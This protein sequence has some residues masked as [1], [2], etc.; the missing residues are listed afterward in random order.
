MQ[1]AKKEKSIKIGVFEEMARQRQFHT[2]SDWSTL[3]VTTTFCFMAI[4]VTKWL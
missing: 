1:A 3:P 4:V 2:L